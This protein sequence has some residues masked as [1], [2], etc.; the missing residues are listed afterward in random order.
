MN[1]HSYYAPGKLLISAEYAVLDG[2]EAWSIPT[3]FGQELCITPAEGGLTWE[4]VNH[5]GDIWFKASWD[6]AGNLLTSSDEEIAGTLHSIL[7][8]SREMGANPFDGFTAQITMDFPNEWGLGSSSTLIACIAKWTEVD[9]HRLFD[10]TLTGSGY[11]VAV[12]YTGKPLLYRID[13]ERKRYIQP[14]AH[15][16]PFAEHLYFVYSGQKQKSHNEVIRFS[17]L[18]EETRNKLAEDITPLTHKLIRATDLSS[19]CE[20]MKAHEKIIGT[21]LARP[22]ANEEWPEI[23]GTLK[24]LGAWGGDFVML[25]TDKTDDIDKLKARGL[26]TV[27]SWSEMLL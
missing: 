20:A 4:S 18:S 13:K 27:L 6:E 24:H 15:V 10:Q 3:R 9:P 19:F 23:E 8:K 25:A 7:M 14:I 1:S 26:T 12:G 5:R 16:P 21:V 22:T 11:D 17:Q 2:A